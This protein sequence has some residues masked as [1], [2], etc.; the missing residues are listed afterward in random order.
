MRDFSNTYI[1]VF[2][3]VLIVIVAVLLSAAA[4]LLQPFQKRNVEIEKKQSILASI[5]VVT[6]RKEAE[7]LYDKYI[8][9]SF[10]VNAKGDK[11]EGVDAFHVDM[12]AEIR[13]PVEERNLPVYVST[14]DDGTVKVIVPVRGKGLWGPVYGYISFNHDY[15]TIFG[16]TF[17]HD[18]E[19]PG[20]GAEIATRQFQEQFL[21]KKIFDD[22][23]NFTSILIQKGG[24][25]P[26]NPHEVDAI[27]GGTLTS[28]GL[29]ASIKDCLSGYV[30]YFK[31]QQEQK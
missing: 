20:L 19:T 17:N 23:G 3:T 2:S 30:A 11:V 27:S 25:A 8:T 28:K 29:E 24:A 26:G 10:V 7:K 1:F 18:K 22:Q 9:G 4:M 21:G 16:A 5:N 31:K 15:N 12:A 14:L 6:S 13:K